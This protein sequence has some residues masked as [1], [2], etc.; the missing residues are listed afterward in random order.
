M[1]SMAPSC[2]SHSALLR[3]S[4]P[5]PPAHPPTRVADHARPT[6]DERHRAMAGS[7][8]MSEPHDGNQVPDM[9]ADRRGVESG[10]SY[11]RSCREHRLHAFG[12]LIEE[13]APC[14]LI[15]VVGSGHDGKI[16]ALAMI[17]SARCRSVLHRRFPISCIVRTFTRDEETVPSTPI[18]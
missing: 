15:E 7:L 14:E 18:H 9:E 5:R 4:A 12:V 13:P 8:Q 3:V 17:R 16:S 1:N 6:T 10:V 2:M 11:D